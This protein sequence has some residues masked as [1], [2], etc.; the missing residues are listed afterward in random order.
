MNLNN[1]PQ[2]TAALLST[3]GLITIV[4]MTWSMTPARASDG[5]TP[6]VEQDCE[7][8]EG[9]AFGLCNAYCEALDCDDQLEPMNACESLRS[10][11]FKKTGA[12]AFPC[13]QT[14]PEVPDPTCSGRGELA[15]DE[16]GCATCFCDE[17]WAGAACSTCD[18]EID[19]CGVCGGDHACFGDI[20]L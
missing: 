18:T 11:Y 8:L 15:Y 12:S 9:A 6:A 19:V 1:K 2:R 13:D 3:A 7:G 17:D 5:V 16:E 20:A 4:A 14:C 10:N